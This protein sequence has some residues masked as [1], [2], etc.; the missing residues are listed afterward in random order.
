LHA[1]SQLGLAP[2]QCVVVEDA[3]SG[4]EAAL[5]AGMWAVGLGPDERV[6][7]AHVVIPNL[8]GVRWSDLRAR[9][10]KAAQSMKR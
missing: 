7:A 1:A 8:A 3:E 2:E 4:V 6:G 10:A 5:A 9:L